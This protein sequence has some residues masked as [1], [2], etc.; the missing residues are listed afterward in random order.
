ML[1]TVSFRLED[2]GKTSTRFF[3]LKFESMEGQVR[4]PDRFKA[5][6]EATSFLGFISI[7]IVAV[8]DHALISDFIN[9]DKWNPISVDSLPF[10]F[11]N[12]GRT[13]ADIIPSVRN[14]AFTGL[15]KVDGKLSWR[16]EGKLPSEGLANLLPGTDPGHQLG[17]ELWIDQEKALL[18]KIRIA[19]QVYPGDSPG[20]VR[21]LDI[22]GFDEPV[23]ISL[24]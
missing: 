19:G 14:P 5:R 20:I 6:V 2:E 23:G 1:D 15:E 13:L 11:S 3:G 9:R 22:Y 7:D 18:R 8:G 16:I 21:V 12:L 24:P 4:M 17:L 10:N